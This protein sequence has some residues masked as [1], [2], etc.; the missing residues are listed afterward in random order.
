MLIRRTG[1][2][3]QTKEDNGKGENLIQIFSRCGDGQCRNQIEKENK[4]REERAVISAGGC[5]QD[6]EVPKTGENYC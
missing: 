4:R 2:C 6:E 1:Y 5:G 3:K